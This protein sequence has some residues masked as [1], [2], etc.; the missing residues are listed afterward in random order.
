MA[1]AEEQQEAINK[2]VNSSLGFFGKSRMQSRGREIGKLISKIGS[3]KSK[4]GIQNVNES[5]FLDLEAIK[6]G[7][8][9]KTYSDDVVE[10]V[11][12]YI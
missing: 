5:I 6:N 7:N 12:N 8:F 2:L 11:K 1:L 10:I 3:Y 4:V 9:H